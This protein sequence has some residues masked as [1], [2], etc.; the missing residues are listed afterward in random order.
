LQE[1]KMKKILYYLIAGFIIVTAG[2]VIS[3]DSPDP[4]VVLE[5]KQTKLPEMLDNYYPP[6]AQGPIYLF[7]MHELGKPFTGIVVDLFENDVE[8]ARN[9]FKDFKE[10]YTDVSKMVPEWQ[11]Q[12]PVEPLNE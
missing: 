9:N 7:K 11:E 1:Q 8:N 12:F 5:S 3:N 2:I 4:N 10:K 6:K